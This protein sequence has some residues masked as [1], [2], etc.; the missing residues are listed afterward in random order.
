MLWRGRPCS[1]AEASL[2]KEGG[3]EPDPAM[4]SIVFL[5]VA[6][7][8]LNKSGLDGRVASTAC[9]R[10]APGTLSCEGADVSDD[11]V[12]DTA[13]VG[14]HEPAA[15]PAPTS[16]I[17][18]AADVATTLG[19]ALAADAA[20]ASGA[21]TMPLLTPLHPLPPPLAPDSL[22]A[23][24]EGRVGREPSLDSEWGVSWPLLRIATAG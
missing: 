9:S 20:P 4:G 16:P 7:F 15:A 23:E 17:T 24:Q 13:A 11:A 18:D 22:E 5:L 1:L 6:S 10:D 12:A 8:L 2:P 19:S 14:A 3:V 21:P